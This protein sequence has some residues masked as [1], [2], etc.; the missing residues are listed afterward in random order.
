VFFS[1][2]FFGFTAVLLII[3]LADIIIDSDEVYQLIGSIRQGRGW[4]FDNFQ[5]HHSQEYFP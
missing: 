2:I 1:L 5:P 4:D 3:M